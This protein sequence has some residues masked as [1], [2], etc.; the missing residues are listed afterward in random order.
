MTLEEYS[1]LL[2][3]L[4]DICEEKEDLREGICCPDEYFPRTALFEGI[5]WLIENGR[6][7]G[8]VIQFIDIN[9]Y[10][11]GLI[12]NDPLP[13]RFYYS[14]FLQFWDTLQELK[15]AAQKRFCKGIAVS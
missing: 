13:A 2:R 3:I 15:T 11:E 4:K 7:T 14:K 5:N 6:I 12:E 8:L 9:E 1:N 10:D